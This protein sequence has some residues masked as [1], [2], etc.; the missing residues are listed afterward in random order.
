[1]TFPTDFTWG[2]ATA[3]YQIEGAHYADGKGP[4]VWDHLCRW[5][6]KV[7]N[8]DTGDVACDHYHKVDD[9]VA[10]MAELGLKAYRFSVSWPRVMP[11]G[12]GA[13]NDKGLA[14]YDRLVDG[15]LGRGIEPW[16]TLFHWD[17]PL[18]LY[19]RGGWLN[20]DSPKWFEEYARVIVD[21]LGDRVAKWITLNEPQC[22]LGLG[23]QVGEHAPGLKLGWADVLRATH[24]AL[25][26]HGRAVAVIRERA[27][28]PPTV[29]WAPVGVIKF[30]ANN[31]AQYEGSAKAA[32]F[33]VNEKSLWNNTWFSDPAIL[34]HY[35]EDGLKVFGEDVPNAPASDFDIIKQ[36][37][38]FYGANI[39]HGDPI[40]TPEDSSK[41]ADRPAGSPRT[42]FGW[43]VEPD[44][45][46]WG[47]KFLHERY[48]LP[49]VV[50]ENGLS[51]HDWIGV[52]GECRDP[53]RIDFTRRYLLRLRDAIA[54]GAKVSG[55]FHWSLMD[56]FEWAEGYKHRFG[57]VHVDFQTLRRT[58]KASAAWYGVVI[59]S[60]GGS[61][62]AG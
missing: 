16:L 54:D 32:M 30:P 3:S 61:L 12:V 55:Y 6:G 27:K 45:L 51:C 37:L 14:F 50:T 59:A 5:P 41:P 2:A 49:V 42:M 23:H 26:A 35:P 52:D 18:A 33:G 53:A 46:Y 24:H 48:G 43:P 40:G 4:S 39:Y 10:L 25:L 28:T 19:H 62:D 21:R 57:L 1:M 20:A 36:P 58:P 47:P 17:Y 22:F 9:D 60:N 44:A 13:V 38:D 56:N 15:L 34:G 7:F 11:D 8:G 31:E 29:G